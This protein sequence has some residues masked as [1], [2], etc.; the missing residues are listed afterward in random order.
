[1]SALTHLALSS[2]P[3]DPASIVAQFRPL[4]SLVDAVDKYSAERIQ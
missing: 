4:I 3:N 1:M 2:S